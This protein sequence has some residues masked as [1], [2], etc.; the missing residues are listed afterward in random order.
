MQHQGQMLQ[1][2]CHIRS[3]DWCGKTADRRN[4]AFATVLTFF[5]VPVVYLQFAR[6]E[7]RIVGEKDADSAAVVP[8]AP[9]EA[10]I[11][12]HAQAREH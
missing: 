5:V 10:P 3:Q 11:P 7:L 8:E 1:R 4:W 6:L 9:K 2:R 12:L